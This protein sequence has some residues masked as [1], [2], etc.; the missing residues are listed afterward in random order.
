MDKLLL[1][2][3]FGTG[4]CKV[5]A[6]TVDGRVAGDCSVEYTTY[7]DHS[8]W[9]EQNPAD[10]YAAC[11]S[12]LK[13]L[14]A[15]GVDL[16][17][18][19]AVSFDGSTH[20]AVLLDGAM[21]PL[22]RTIM[23]T[24]QRSTAECA[25]L[26][27]MKDKIFQTAYQMP[28]PTWTLPQMMWLQKH[29]PEV[30][31]KVRHIL[32]VKDYVRYLFTGV[33]VTDYIEAQGTLFYDMKN[34]KWS[35]ELAALA[36]IAPEVL[37][38]LVTPTTRT[39][40]VTAQAARDTGLPE[41]TPVICGTSDS[42]VEDYGAG[43]I[44]P[45]DAIIKLATAGNV[46]VMTGKAFPDPGTLTY[47][48]VI[49]GMWYTVAATNAAA[50]CQRWFRDVF[51]GEEAAF[52]EASG[53]KVYALMDE[54]AEKSPLGANGIFFHPY[55]QGE[56]SPYWDAALRSSFTGVSIASTKGDFIRALF[57]GVAFSLLDC[58]GLIDKMGLPVKR[59][60]FIGGGAKSRLWSEIVCNIFNLPVQVPAI[61]DASFGTALLAGTGIG[62]W[63]NSADAVRNCLAIDREISPDPE[64]AA[65]YRE[66][67][68]EYKAIHDALA[69]IYGARAG[70]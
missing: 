32:F 43:A 16:R 30:M 42:A 51:C 61:G 65:R 1:G 20:N 59:I 9:S 45:G 19:A 55:L 28:T 53:K 69:P 52:A 8:G 12:A 2:I 26:R 13:K 29:E 67:F 6:I 39:G 18:V 31:K 3:D 68:A 5:T 60:F 4:G 63:Q 44:E 36:G 35:T 22:R 7:H 57:E 14:A 17:A 40:S 48:H 47:S 56:R 49:P 27:E 37:P 25:V 34:Q 58:Y 38:E 24:D 64:K 70:K 62:L 46:N 23:W 11:C 10:W 54:L 41:G 21:K 50:L 66:L 33:A 15:S